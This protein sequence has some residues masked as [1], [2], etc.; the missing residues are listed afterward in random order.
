MALR[1]ESRAVNAHKDVYGVFDTSEHRT[2]TALF[3]GTELEVQSLVALLNEAREALGIKGEYV[4]YTDDGT[5]ALYVRD[6]AITLV[7]YSGLITLKQA[8][9]A[10]HEQAIQGDTVHE[11]IIKL[12]NIIE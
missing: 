3:E 7:T 4:F 11:L 8:Q 6:E 10:V 9:G 12:L 1:Y 5:V 2:A